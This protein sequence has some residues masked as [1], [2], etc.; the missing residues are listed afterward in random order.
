MRYLG[1]LVLFLSIASPGW[2]AVHLKLTKHESSHVSNPV[3]RAK[4]AG[5]EDRA[6][7]LKMTPHNK[8]PHLGKRQESSLSAESSTVESSQAETTAVL[9]TQAATSIASTTVFTS[10][11]SAISPLSTGSQVDDSPSQSDTATSE[12]QSA[13]P[14]ESQQGGLQLPEAS[15]TQIANSPITTLDVEDTSQ[16]GTIYTIDVGVE[17]VEL[18]VHID[19]GSSQFWAAHE[20]CKEC[21]E[22]GMTTINTTLPS[23]CGQD[24]NYLTIYYAMGWV[25]GCLV[26]TT[27]TLGEDTLSSY[28]ILAVTQAGDGLEKLGDYYSGLIGLASHDD[29]PSV[30]STL[31][32]QGAIQEPIVGFYLPRAGEQEDSEITFGDPTTS[33]YADQNAY[34]T[35]PRQGASNGNY[36]VRMDSF[37]V[38]GSATVFGGADCY[39]DTGSSGIAIPKDLLSQVYSSVYGINSE[40]STATPPCQAPGNITGLHITFGGRKFEVPYQ[41]LVYKSDNSTCGPMLSSYQGETSD[42]WIF[43]DAFLHNVYHSVNVETGEVKIFDLKDG[44]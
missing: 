44:K 34:V 19:T 16:I 23:D 29:S 35:L 13:Q 5:L 22:N 17:G 30:V 4:V 20:S 14:S 24:D 43:G 18:P 8:S 33:E 21:K 11:D 26:N 27:L 15:S 41:D 12:S 40:D 10:S 39:L 38:A 9:S 6:I 42:K 7:N 2:A 28:P 3:K 31:Y 36:I 37:E 32:S 25:K 1:S